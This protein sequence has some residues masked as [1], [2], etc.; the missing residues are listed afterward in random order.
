MQFAWSI[1]EGLLNCRA[2]TPCILGLPEG[3]DSSAY[4]LLFEV[5]KGV[6]R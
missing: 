5:G 4:Y 6:R 2:D 3:V 1:V